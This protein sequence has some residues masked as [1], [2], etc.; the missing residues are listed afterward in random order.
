MAWTFFSRLKENNL[1][2]HLNQIRKYFLG[3]FLK[4]VKPRPLC[5]IIHLAL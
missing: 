4:A 1:V 2:F 5:P 3:K